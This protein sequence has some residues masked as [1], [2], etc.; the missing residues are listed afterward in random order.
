MTDP[1]LDINTAHLL[2]R[3]LSGK[4]TEAER[5]EVVRQ[6]NAEPEILEVFADAA[7]LMDETA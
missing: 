4:C 6:L 3:F 1:A 7:A 5:E 2:A